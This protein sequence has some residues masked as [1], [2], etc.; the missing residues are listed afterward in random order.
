M[1]TPEGRLR[2]GLAFANLQEFLPFVEPPRSLRALDIG[3]GTG[4]VA[5]CLARLGVHVTLLDSSQEMLE[6]ANRT[7]Q[8]TGAASKIT[9]KEGDAIQAANLFRGECFDV[10]LCHNVLEFVDE[11]VAVLR[12]ASQLMHESSVLSVLVRTQAGEVLKA[13][14]QS[15]DLAAAERSLTAECGRENLFGGKVRLFTFEGLHAMLRDASLTATATRGVRVF[16]DYLPP[17]ISLEAEF[18]RIFELERK[19]GIRP[20]FRAVARYAQFFARRTSEAENG[21]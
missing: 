5:L 9:L 8:E 12:S 3:A 10:I 21:T 6:L 14:I 15:G 13:A 20:E 2:A 7:A 16:S 17:A 18:E 4:A 1:E 19:L 11:P